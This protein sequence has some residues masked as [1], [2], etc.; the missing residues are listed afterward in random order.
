M[1]APDLHPEDLIE[2]D[3]QGRLTASERVRLEAHVRHCVACRVERMA[4][5]DFQDEAEPLPE[6]AEVMRVIARLLPP[7]AARKRARSVLTSGFGRALLGAAVALVTGLGIA[8]VRSP[9]IWSR[10]RRTASAMV[11]APSSRGAA[12]ATEG[13]GGVD[14]APRMSGADLAVNPNRSEGDS[15]RPRDFGS[16]PAVSVSAPAADRPSA[17]ALFERAAAARHAGDHSRA[18]DLYRSLIQAFPGSPEAHTALALLGR[19]LLDEGDDDSAVAQFD[20]YLQ[21]KGVLEQDALVGRAL[22]LERLGRTADA[23]RAWLAILRSYPNS[24]HA[25]RARTH[26][27]T[28]A[29]R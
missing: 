5:V 16:T 29:Q 18:A 23:S 8:A 2:R 10:A 4:R 24:A 25:D 1:T 28:L 20:R 13:V 12:P 6:G 27:A 17:S 22:A 15:L 21:S 7:N 3:E 19:M 14:P 11:A 26:L 9:N